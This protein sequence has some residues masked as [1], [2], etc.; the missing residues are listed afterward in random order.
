[1]KSSDQEGKKIREEKYKK[2]QW[3]YCLSIYDGVEIL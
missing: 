1:M 3:I 2:T